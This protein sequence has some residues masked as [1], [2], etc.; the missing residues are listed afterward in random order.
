MRVLIGVITALV[1]G[2]GCWILQI[3]A[4]GP[5]VLSGG[6]L[7]VAIARPCISA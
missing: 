7:V 2:A 6:L 5:P 3:P 1:V 4:P